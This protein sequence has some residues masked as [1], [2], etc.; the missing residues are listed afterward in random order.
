[1]N[2]GVGST[3]YNESQSNIHRSVSFGAQCTIHSHVWIGEGVTVGQNTKIQAFAFIPKGVTIG[4]NVFI[5][6]HVCFTN[7][8]HP[9]SNGSGWSETV[10]EDK[11]V[12]GARAVILPGITLGE[13]CVIGA[14]AI[15]TKD[16][17]AGETWVSPPACP[18]GV[19]TTA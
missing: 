3:L 13:G 10:V 15:V 18:V 16:V 19:L 14:G 12:I 6:P 1:M 9:P 4:R 7:D 17:P 5:G 11:V 2:I 8:K